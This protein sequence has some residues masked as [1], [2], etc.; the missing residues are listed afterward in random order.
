MI[1]PLFLFP[2]FEALVVFGCALVTGTLFVTV[3]MLVGYTRLLGVAHTP[4]I[5]LVAF[6]VTR[7][8][9]V[10]ANDFYGWWLRAVIVLDAISVVFDAANVLRYLAGERDEMVTGLGEREPL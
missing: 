3:T 8:D 9:D 1:V 6:L 10:P 7:L 4:W 2:R 5:F